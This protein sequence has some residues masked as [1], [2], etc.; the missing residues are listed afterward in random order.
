MRE[1]Y[2]TNHR[3]VVTGIGVISPLGLNMPE[4]WEALIEGRSGVG[5]ITAFDTTDFTTKIAAEVTNFDPLDYID[6]KMAKRLD[7]FAQ[8][9]A[10]A[11]LQAVDQ[12]NLKIDTTN[13]ND[14]GIIIGSGTGGLGTLSHQ[15][16]VLL[17]KG[18]GRVSPF[19][20]PMMIGDSAPAIV[21]ILLGAHGPNYCTTSSC[22][23]GSD[24]IGTAFEILRRGDAKA[25]LAGGSE[26]A[27]VPVATATF[28]SAHA[29]STRND[30]PQGASRPFDA[31][32]DGF[33][34]GEGAA[35]LV[36]EEMSY[37]EERGAPILAE[38][39]GYGAS[40][41]AFHITQP[42]E[43]GTGGALA[44]R[45]ALAKAG[46]KPTEVDYINAHG[47]STPLNDRGETL[48]IKTVFGEHAYRIPISSTKSMTGHLLGAS[49][50]LEA[51]IS[52]FTIKNGV[53][54]PTIN[55]THPDPECDLDYVPHKARTAKVTAVI[56]NSF[57]FG[58]HNSV[59]A[60]RR[61]SE[62]G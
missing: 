62:G 48:A 31:E 9:A 26:A 39:A 7:R 47:T 54:P 8:M 36:L 43:N 55:L 38:I 40:S 53:V 25:M 41:D 10:A 32:R 58:G 27:V 56:S 46:L 34:I 24:A 23:S 61:Y 45:R 21:S 57:G 14:I 22:S 13:N 37:A 6:R 51:A 42:D 35:I 33:V 20:S 50:A 5:H 18:P 15:V 29:L 52:I 12:A 49:G 16:E 4:T 1:N 28:G 3:V 11:G 19:L 60:F 44:I 30:D 2:S 17:E 59:L